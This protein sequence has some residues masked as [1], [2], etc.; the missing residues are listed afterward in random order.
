MLE[1]LIFVTEKAN[2]LSFDEVKARGA[3][4]PRTVSSRRSSQSFQQ[5][6]NYHRAT[7]NSASTGHSSMRA[8]DSRGMHSAPAHATARESWGN[9]RGSSGYGA[10]GASR[11]VSVS[12]GAASGA[13]YGNVSSSGGARGTRRSRSQAQENLYDSAYVARSERGRYRGAQVGY[14]EEF[15]RGFDYETRRDQGYA[16]DRAS[17]R[18]S[19]ARNA[20]TRSNARAEKESALQKLQKRFRSAKADREFDRTIGAQERKAQANQ[21][22]QQGSRAAVYE[23]RMGSTHRKSA[24]MQDEGKEKGSHGFS[25]PFSLPFNGSLSVVATRGV[26][27]VAVLALTMFMLYPPCQ[28][29]YNETRQLQQLQAEYDALTAYNAQMQSQIDYLNTDEGLEDY[30]RSEL[31][32][33]REDEQV[34]TVE[35]V[36]S[37][38]DGSPQTNDTSSPL[39]EEVP[40]PDTWYSGVLD[41][42][43]G[44][45]R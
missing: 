37:S 22:A 41:V 23:M 5:S 36:Q 21:R 42:F 33:I 10:R 40:A 1:G 28:S 19:G 16:S 14:A 17:L 26:V 35:G 20:Q 18:D 25:L 30:A 24:R 3:S 32:W 29:Y 8:R 34:V 38:V 15:D 11:A 7:T 6:L 13:A 43:F 39:N 31:G 45:G 4:A 27:A 12:H 9:R 44:Y 2:I